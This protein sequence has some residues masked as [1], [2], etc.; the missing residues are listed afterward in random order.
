MSLHD[1]PAP[2]VARC[3]ARARALHPVSDEV[4]A[5]AVAELS[6][7]YTRSR[8]DIGRVTGSRWALAARLRFF[9]PRDLLKVV[10]PLAALERAGA[11][12]PGPTW[13]VLDLGAGLGATSFGVARFAAVTG[14][15]ER[16]SV[17]AVDRDAGA[18]AEMEA[19]AEGAPALGLAPIALETR[20]LDLASAEARRGGPF[21]L[22][23]LGLAMNERSGALAQRDP[24]AQHDDDASSAEL[25]RALASALAP[26]G[27]LVVLEPALRSTARAL[28]RV[29]DALAASGPPYVLW[30]CPHDA[31]CPMLANERDW[32]H[33]EL[34][35][36]LPP[37]L[38]RLAVDAGLRD[39]KLTYAALVLRNEPGSEL[40]E[41]RAIAAPTGANE[42]ASRGRALRL[43]SG[44]LP[45]KGKLEAIGCTPEGTL[46][47]L[48]RLDRHASGANAALAGARRGDTLV[49]EGAEAASGRLRIDA[50]TNIHVVAS[51]A[52]GRPTGA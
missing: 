17:V 46:V 8:D 44:L 19:L 3:E 7:V 34:P 43:V 36:E 10:G 12:P 14:A 2:L 52:R 26:G 6:R 4:F 30:P 15:A 31:P 45:S 9:L 21:D 25:L 22:V 23:V 47:R 41:G 24:L 51:L 37:P 20:R 28:Q 13:R 42:I 5:R 48:M 18:L 1:I 38:A 39:E 11:L 35:V 49:V 32:C 27:A 33:A 16:L 50:S 29:R 40:A